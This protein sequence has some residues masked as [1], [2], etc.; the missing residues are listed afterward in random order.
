MV[1]SR[2]RRGA[3]FAWCGFFRRKKARKCNSGKQTASLLHAAVSRSPACFRCWERIDSRKISQ[4][5]RLPRLPWVSGRKQSLLLKRIVRHSSRRARIEA[6]HA[7]GIREEIPVTSLS[8]SGRIAVQA[9]THVGTTTAGRYRRIREEIST[10][11]RARR[12]RTG[13][14]CIN[15]ASSRRSRRIAGR[16]A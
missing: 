4:G 2:K 6:D 13:E 7:A 8:R 3:E 15:V 12:G 1:Q 16:T 5:R 11:R 9:E 14:N 10:L